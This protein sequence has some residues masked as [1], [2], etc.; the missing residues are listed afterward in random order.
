MS[1]SI[2]LSSIDHD[3]YRALLD[4]VSSGRRAETVRLLA[5]GPRW[6][7]PTAAARLARYVERPVQLP[8]LVLDLGLAADPPRYAAEAATWLMG[9]ETEDLP[10]VLHAAS[11]TAEPVELPELGL[12]VELAGD[13]HVRAAIDSA[14]GGLSPGVRVITPDAVRAAARA[15]A[16]PEVTTA[17]IDPLLRRVASDLAQVFSEATANG[18]AVYVSAI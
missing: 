12:I 2:V 3:R 17:R 16:S 13:P 15:L 6:R 1:R 10:S 14:L 11:A 5:M 7:S 9:M 18:W 4:S 8:W